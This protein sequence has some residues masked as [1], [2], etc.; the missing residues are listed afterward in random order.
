ME[1][2]YQRNKHNFFDSLTA[3]FVSHASYPIAFRAQINGSI[4]SYNANDK[5]GFAGFPDVSNIGISLKPKNLMEIIAKDGWP[6]TL[7]LEVHNL[8]PNK[9]SKNFSK[10]PNTKLTGLQ[11]LFNSTAV[12]MYV[13]YYES[14][15]NK[16]RKKFGNDPSNWPKVWNFGRVVRNAFSHGGE[17]FFSNPKSKLVSWKGLY[18]SPK[19]NGRQVLFNDMGIADVIILLEEIDQVI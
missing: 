1:K 3:F 9:R 5:I 11:G 15:I 2:I 8:D 10:M 6:T 18:Y 14:N 19:D 13:E 16:V 7:E 12:P 17:V 4:N